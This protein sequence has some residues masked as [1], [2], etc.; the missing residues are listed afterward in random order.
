MDVAEPTI[1][2]RIRAL[3]VLFKHTDCQE[4]LF[5]NTWDFAAACAALAVKQDAIFLNEIIDLSR[6]D[7]GTVVIKRPIFSGKVNA[8]LELS[9]ETASMLLLRS[10]CWR[11]EPRPTRDT[12]VE[13]VNVSRP[14]SHGVKR[15]KIVEP[16]QSDN[17]LSYAKIVFGVG[18]GL[19]TAEKV[20]LVSEAAQQCG[21]AVAASR[22]LVDSGLLPR[23]RQVGQSGQSVSPK[24]YVAFGISG[25]VQHLEGIRNSETIIAV[26]TDEN[27][28]IFAVADYGS[29]ADAVD[30][31]KKLAES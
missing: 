30:I 21:A 29:H 31:V 4:A 23:S 20:A 22:P 1:H 16:E 3:E 10:G 13:D 5:P 25:A 7:D 26:N 24:V 28:P 27:A 14:E 9:P 8:L 11:P 15:V 2:E 6:K 12:I 19:G 18:R 17:D